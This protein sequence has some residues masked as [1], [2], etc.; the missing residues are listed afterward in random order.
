MKYLFVFF[1]FENDILIKTCF[2]IDYVCGK[3]IRRQRG[4]NCLKKMRQI[5]ARFLDFW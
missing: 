5:L 3:T 2:S 1:R 4:D